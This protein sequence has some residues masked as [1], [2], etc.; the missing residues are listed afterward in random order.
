MLICFPWIFCEI[1]ISYDKWKWGLN[2]V[3]GFLD[4]GEMVSFQETI[5]QDQWHTKSF[6]QKEKR[7]KKKEALTREPWS[8][9]IFWSCSQMHYLPLTDH[10]IPFSTFYSPRLEALKQVWK[11]GKANVSDNTV[12]Q[13]DNPT[14]FPLWCQQDTIPKGK[15]AKGRIKRIIEIRPSQS[16]SKEKTCSRLSL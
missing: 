7:G 3:W 10:F 5:F 9:G 4:R 12:Y 6:I 8:W 1:Q 13:T 16:I 11:K 2:L 14:E 15:N